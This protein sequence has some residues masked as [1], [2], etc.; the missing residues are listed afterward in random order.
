V[1]AK[2][3]VFVPGLFGWGPGELGGFPYWGGALKPFAGTSFSTHEAKCGPISS[4][5]DRACEVFARIKGTKVDYGAGHSANEGHARFSRDYTGRGFVPDWSKA[6]PVILIGHS[7]GAA[8][9]VGTGK[10]RAGEAVH[11]TDHLDCSI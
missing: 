4:F 7:A 9:L 2:H 3:I 5:H 6:N 1:K 8:R 11:E 10:A